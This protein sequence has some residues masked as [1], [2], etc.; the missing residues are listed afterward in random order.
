MK[1]SRSSDVQTLPLIL[2]PKCNAGAVIL[3][4]YKR[5]FD[6]AHP[7]N[8]WR[9]SFYLKGQ[10]LRPDYIP[11]GNINS[12]DKFSFTLLKLSNFPVQLIK[13]VGGGGMNF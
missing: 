6:L 12:Y 3:M 2:H 11:I 7:E 9:L 8:V 4:T 1:S 5:I 10:R 13:I